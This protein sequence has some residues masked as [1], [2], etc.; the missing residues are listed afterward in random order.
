MP[1]Q[2]VVTR[3][4]DP[5]TRRPADGGAAAELAARM[6]RLIARAKEIAA[7]VAHGLHGRRR[8]G[9]GE[10]FWQYRPFMPGE[11][12][13]R[14]DWR[15]SARSDHYYVREREWEAARDYLV[16]MDCSPS[17]AFASSLAADYKLDRAVTLGLALADVLVRGGE[18]AGALGL[19]APISAR[20]VID[21]L[22]RALD[23]G[24]DDA[25]R[26]ELPPAA[27]LRARTRLALISD[28]LC[29]P[30]ALAARLEEFADAG[31]TG[32]LLMIADPSEETLPFAGETRFLDTDGGPSFH[33][34]DPN[35]LRRAYVEKLGEHRAR[36][37]EAAGRAGFVFL[38]HHTDRPAAEGLLALAMA[39]LDHAAF[40]QD[41]PSADNV[42]DS[43]SLERALREKPASTFS[44]RAP[45]GERL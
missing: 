22:A 6:P 2:Q 45:G 33:A 42:I 35:A 11:A 26:T 16:W 23:A 41:R 5:S 44:Q 29:D 1:L 17:M 18:R 40:G 36:L 24:A 21:R 25:I 34:G 27:R 43:K 19:S 9:A 10:T 15:R 7:S 20:D 32:A 38:S 37:R 3:A 28:F 12:A 14:I 31:A 39:L 13:H 8:A 30:D 4:Y